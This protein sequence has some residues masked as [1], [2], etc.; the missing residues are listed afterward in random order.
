MFL[1][2]N[3]TTSGELSSSRSSGCMWV[4][5]LSSGCGDGALGWTH[6]LRHCT[7]LF[8]KSFPPWVLP[9]FGW[10]SWVGK[11]SI[12]T[13]YNILDCRGNLGKRVR[14]T[15]KTHPGI[16]GDDGKYCFLLTPQE[17]GG[18]EVGEPRNL[19]PRL[20]DG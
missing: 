15:W 5:G 11:R 14:L 8:T 16:P 19:F 12:V 20:G 3:L 7:R 9:R 18:G 6:K 10:G 13:F 1:W 2:A 17:Q 4:F